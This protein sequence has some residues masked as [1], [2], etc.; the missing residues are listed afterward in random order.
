[1][2]PRQ[3]AAVVLLVLVAG[4]GPSA[5]EKQAATGSHEVAAVEGQAATTKAR[6]PAEQNHAD[7]T[8][9]NLDRQ[10]PTTQLTKQKEVEQFLAESLQQVDQSDAES[11]Q[12]LAADVQ[13]R[14][15][16]KRATDER[17]RRTQEEIDIRKS[18]IKWLQDSLRTD[19]ERFGLLSDQQQQ[20]ILGL[21]DRFDAGE[22]VGLEGRLWLA[23]FGTAEERRA[24]NEFIVGRNERLMDLQ[25]EGKVLSY[26]QKEEV[27][28]DKTWKQ[29]APV[30][31]ECLRWAKE[32]RDEHRQ[33]SWQRECDELKAYVDLHHAA[34]AAQEARVKKARQ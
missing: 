11:T 21:K 20:V 27:V 7:R 8:T 32:D 24:L 3:L 2:R 13:E 25:L 14:L 19:E 26:I 12:R 34:V 17:I 29:W 15:E 16:A 10:H 30:Y 28:V 18:M 5:E 33:D 9:G 1:M 6:V 31:A 23:Q 4:C 22:D